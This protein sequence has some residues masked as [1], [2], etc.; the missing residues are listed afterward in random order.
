MRP[1]SFEQVIGPGMTV[2]ICQSV[3]LR[4]ITVLYYHGVILNKW[5]LSVTQGPGHFACT[6]T[7]KGTTS[8]Q[9]AA[10]WVGKS[11]SSHLT[12]FWS[13]STLQPTGVSETTWV[14]TSSMDRIIHQDA[15]SCP[16]AV[17]GL[18][19]MKTSR[20]NQ[21]SYMTAVKLCCAPPCFSQS[22]LAHQ[23]VPATLN[24]CL[25]PK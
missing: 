17:K 8:S 23:T 14:K 15:I 11:P 25:N 21:V 1:S 20:G 12:C 4:Q 3:N 24:R 7:R 5:E 2:I 16:W 13:A 22:Q 10:L 6:T 9:S 19:K 18:W